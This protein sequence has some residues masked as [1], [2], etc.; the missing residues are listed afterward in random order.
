MS[1]GHGKILGGSFD[2]LKD[3]WCVA[4]QQYAHS[5]PFRLAQVVL[6]TNQFGQF[7]THEQAD[8]SRV[9]SGL[10]WPLEA[11]VHPGL[12]LRRVPIA[13]LWRLLVDAEDKA[14]R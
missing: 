8:E 7:L 1:N 14:A 4:G 5:A 11:Q 2:G 10:N 13:C 9:A 12:P 3:R 6:P